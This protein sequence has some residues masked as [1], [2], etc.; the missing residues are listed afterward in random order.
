MGQ[1]IH[2]LE[3]NLFALSVTLIMLELNKYIYTPTHKKYMCMLEVPFE[4]M[5]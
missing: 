3:N 1:F 2:D 5:F 4:E